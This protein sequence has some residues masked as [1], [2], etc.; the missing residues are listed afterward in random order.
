MLVMCSSTY[1]L[2]YNVVVHF[3]KLASCALVKSTRTVLLVRA[4]MAVE[5]DSVLTTL[6][7][8]TPRKQDPDN[9]NS[10]ERLSLEAT[11]INQ[12]FSQQILKEGQRDTFD[13]PNPFFS[14]ED[15]AVAENTT[16]A[17]QPASVGYRYRKFTFGPELSIVAR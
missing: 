2:V 14:D 12:N 6:K 15:A 16:E 13:M 10:P 1:T 9:I 5:T 17:S 4:V 7:C 8:L 3:S 11:S